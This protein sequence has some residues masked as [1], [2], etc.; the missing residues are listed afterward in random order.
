MRNT[1]TRNERARLEVYAAEAEKLRRP[2]IRSK[3]TYRGMYKAAIMPAH[4]VPAQGN[5]ES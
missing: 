1:I 2:L 5:A 3:G 4:F